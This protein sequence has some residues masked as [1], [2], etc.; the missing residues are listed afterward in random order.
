MNIR[1]K[2]RG[3]RGRTVP[4]AAGLTAVMF[5]DADGMIAKD[6][7]KIGSFYRHCSRA[8]EAGVDQGRDGIYTPHS[9][10]LHQE[11]LPCSDPVNTCLI[12]RRG[13]STLR[14]CPCPF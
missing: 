4:T 9:N 10:L 14:T 8:S 1:A 3:D 11:T 12:P 13:S 5:L 7:M 6:G 2:E